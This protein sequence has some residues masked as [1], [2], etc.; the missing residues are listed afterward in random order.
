MPIAE[1]ASYDGL[2]LAELVRHKEVTPAE[3][4]EEAITRIEKH[5][6]KLNAVVFKAYDDARARAG[7]APQGPFGGVPFLLKDINGDLEGWPTTFGA[8]FMKDF[9]A[10][11]TYELTRRFLNAGLIPLGKTNVP[12]IGSMPVTEPRF[13]GPCRNPWHTDHT[14][15]GSSGGSAA[16]VAA[17]AVPLAHANDGGGSIRIPAASCG[18]F[19]MKPTRM[20]NPSGPVLGDFMDGLAQEHVVTRTVRDS[21]AMLDCTAGPSIGDPYWAPPQTRPY[22]EEVTREPGTLRVALM[23]TNLRT[24]EKVHPDCV[25]AAEETAKLLESLGHRIEEVSPSIDYGMMSQA[26]TAIWASAATASLDAFSM[27]TGKPLSPGA[28]EPLT[29]GLYELGKQITGG[30]YMQSKILLQ[31]IGRTMGQFHET[32]DVI[33]TPTLG[34]PPARIGQF[35]TDEADVEKAFEPLLDY[36]P[37]TPMFNITGQPSMSMPLHWNDAGLPI[38]VMLSARFGDEA[39]LF[40]LAAQVEKAQPWIDR[41]PPLWD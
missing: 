9:R 6:G 26:F 20:R 30:Q 14:P 37:F 24:G 32:Y 18:L 13:Y 34:Q 8:A 41:K 19:G 1:Y 11:V 21:A 22:L 17:G 38:G 16:M 23:T 7:N 27:M 31:M 2:G 10:P 29:W 12:E 3:L 25:K 15:G 36:L 39:T 4:A 33:L 5:N 35:T 28:F 40:R